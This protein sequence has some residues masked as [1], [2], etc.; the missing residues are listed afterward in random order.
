MK[1]YFN[2]KTKNFN[3]IDLL[4]HKGFDLEANLNDLII[5]SVTS[6]IF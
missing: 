5:K 2:L 1:Y 4:D 3:K 6:L